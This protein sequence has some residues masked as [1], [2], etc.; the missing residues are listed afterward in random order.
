METGRTR[1]PVRRIALI[2][3]I[4]VGLCLFVY[5][6]PAFFSEKQEEPP[7]VRL[8]LGGTS[9][10]FFMMDKWKAVYFKEKGIKVHYS[11]T[12]ST[13][14]VTKMLDDEFTIGFTHR[15]VSEKQRKMALENGGEVVQ[16]P[17]L[18]CGVVPVYNV[19][20][21]KDKPPL[22]FTGEVLADIF[23]GKVDRW[24]DPALRRLNDGVDLPA[25]KIAVVH[26]EDSSGTTFI[27]ADYLHGASAGWRE[28]L[29]PAS[30]TIR[31]PVGTGIRRTTGVAA[32]VASTE[33]S[34][35]YVDLLFAK[36]RNLSY[37]ALENKDKTAFIHAEPENLTAAAKGLN[38][39]ISEDLTFGLTNKSGK[40]AYPVAG[41]IWAV[42]YRVQPAS[43]RQDVVDFLS[44]VTHDGQRLSADRLYAPLPPAL[45]ERVE[46]KL[47][48]IE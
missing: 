5:F 32:L 36:V 24:N 33:G 8:K 31:W 39:E 11:S 2:L 4:G 6:S 15:P 16:I 7:P 26:R 34:I 40:D 19:K 18:I 46:K 28:K 13:K 37:A 48:S 43:R 22:K 17:V 3:L 35:G 1:F 47:K 9:A 12:G 27:F 10:T 25:T 23:L 44:W 38:T 20:E 45:V 41:A 14:G 21:L 29:G 30:S 42:C